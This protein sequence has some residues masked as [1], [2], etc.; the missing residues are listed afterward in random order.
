[1]MADCALV[2]YEAQVLILHLQ[3]VHDLSFVDYQLQFKLLETKV[4]WFTC[5]APDCGA[6]IKHQKS[7]LTKHAFTAHE[8]ELEAFESKFISSGDASDSGNEQGSRK[9]EKVDVTN[10]VNWSKGRC[11]FVCSV[12]LK[13]TRESAEFWQHA[14]VDHNF[15]P[16]EYRSQFGDPCVE[17]DT[18]ECKICSKK[19]RHDITDIDTHTT[20]VHQL[21]VKSYFEKYVQPKN[22]GLGKIRPGPKSKTQKNGKLSEIRKALK[23]RLPTTSN[24]P[25]ADNQFIQ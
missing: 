12:C 18:T 1:M 13:E 24:G 8:L 2:F 9:R 20:K 6:K 4:E 15:E 17:P 16:D 22:K 21:S 25:K 7:S 3:K 14:A 19:L 23:S 10:F 5:P 11:L